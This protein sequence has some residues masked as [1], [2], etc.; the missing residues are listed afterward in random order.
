MTRLLR[1]YNL[2][3]ALVVA[4]LGMALALGWVSLDESQMAAVLGFIAA[5]LLVLRFMVTPTAS[6]NLPIDT[7]VNEFSDADTGI[8][9]R[10]R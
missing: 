7:L 4:G 2:I 5:V 9:V 3:S 10:Y 8:V 6:P 1:E